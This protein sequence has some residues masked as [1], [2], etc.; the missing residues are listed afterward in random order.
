M[1]TEWIQSF[2]QCGSQALLVA[3]T[4][5]TA[6]RIIAVDEN[7]WQLPLTTH[8]EDFLVYPACLGRTDGVQI[9][10]LDIDSLKRRRGELF[11]RYPAVCAFGSGKYRDL[12]LADSFLDELS[13]RR[14]AGERHGG[15]WKNEDNMMCV[16]MLSDNDF[17]G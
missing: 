10:E 17:D 6:G 5:V 9:K 15:T 11:L 3:S 14:V 13:N 12:V 16:S 2:P 4:V 1:T 8:L 7:Q